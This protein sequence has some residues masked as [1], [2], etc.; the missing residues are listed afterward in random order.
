MVL[1][2]DDPNVILISDPPYLKP[3]AGYM[4]YVATYKHKLLVGAK[5]IRSRQEIPSSYI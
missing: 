4:Y 3:V 5:V 2:S 1:K